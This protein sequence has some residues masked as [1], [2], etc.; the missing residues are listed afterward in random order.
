MSATES[1]PFFRSGLELAA[2]HPPWKGTEITLFLDAED[3][4]YFSS[5]TVDDEQTVFAQGEIKHQWLN[6][7][8][9][10]IAVDGS[11]QN[12]VVDITENPGGRPVALK[13]SAPPSGSLPFS[14]SDF[15]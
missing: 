5:R 15:D 10:G 12:Q 3:T 2:F 13:L 8:Q 11:Y 6:D 9:A 14:W 4:R 7:W 1:S